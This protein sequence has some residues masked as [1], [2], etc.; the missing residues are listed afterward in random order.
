MYIH[1]FFPAV[2]SL[3]VIELAG[4]ISANTVRVE[5]S[6]P[7]GGATVTGYVVHY[8]DG[9]TDRMKSVVAS[10]TST[11]ISSLSSGRTYTISVEATSSQL[12]GESDSVDIFMTNA[13]LGD[14]ADADLDNSTNADL[15]DSTS[16]SGN[17]NIFEE[18]PLIVGVALVALFVAIIVIAGIAI[19]AVM[20]AR[21][22]YYNYFID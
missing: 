16:S 12:S 22:R 15:D 21:K 11:D 5:W 4:Q 17:S 2:A 3:P 14:S 10:S 19:A 7:S 18:V 1:D 8:S 13:D 6:Q 20:I 9:T